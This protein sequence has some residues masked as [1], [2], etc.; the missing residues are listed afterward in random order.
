M[1]QASTRKRLAKLS[2]E[3]VVRSLPSP[4]FLKGEECEHRHAELQA[5]FDR[6]PR[7]VRAMKTRMARELQKKA[8]KP[9]NIAR[10]VL[11]A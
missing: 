4:L 8:R 3:T 1:A 10:E 7:A 5:Q 11:N 2:W 9:T 6:S